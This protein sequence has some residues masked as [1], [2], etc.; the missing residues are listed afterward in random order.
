VE[1]NTRVGS[2]SLRNFAPAATRW[3]T[4][5]LEKYNFY[6]MPLAFQSPAEAIAELIGKQAPAAGY[7]P[8]N[9][10]ALQQ[11]WAWYVGI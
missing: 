10:G 1:A 3:F 8:G 5:D 9:L 11:G 4:V 2:A 7:D 6:L